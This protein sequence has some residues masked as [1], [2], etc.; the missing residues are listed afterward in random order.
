MYLRIK[1]GLDFMMA[2]AGL[3]VLSPV[4]L[5]LVIWI[6]LDSRGPILFRQ[7]RVGNA[8][9]YAQRYAHAFVKEPGA[10]YYESREVFAQDQSGRAAADYQYIERGYGCG[11]AAAGALESI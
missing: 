6:K 10:V 4:F 3:A 1:R 7:K 8:D 9:G 11:R 2:L 5:I